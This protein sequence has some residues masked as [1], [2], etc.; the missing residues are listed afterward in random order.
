MI[1]VMLLR[2][3]HSIIANY[4]KTSLDLTIVLSVLNLV[5][6]PLR[7]LDFETLLSSVD[8]PLLGSTLAVWLGLFLPI[9]S[10]LPNDW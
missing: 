9:R 3:H 7:F 6:S 10:V 1:N 5:L 2:T 8:I 4:L